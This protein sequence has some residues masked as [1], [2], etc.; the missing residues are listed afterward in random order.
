MAYRHLCRPGWPSTL[1]AALANHNYCVAITQ[2]AQNLGRPA[3]HTSQ[4]HGLPKLPAPPT[5]AQMPLRGPMRYGR[6][7]YSIADRPQTETNCWK[8]SN[9]KM[10]MAGAPAI[11]RVYFDHKRAAANDLGD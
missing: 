7:E 10:M 5:P 11:K 2:V 9:P 6:S 1:D 8:G 3:W 4:P